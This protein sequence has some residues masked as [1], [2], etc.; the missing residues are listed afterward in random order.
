[1]AV[2]WRRFQFFS[3]HVLVDNDESV[4]EE[5]LFSPASISTAPESAAELVRLQ[6][7]DEDG[8]VNQQLPEQSLCEQL[9]YLRDTCAAAGRNLLALGDQNG[10]IH[11]FDRQLHIHVFDAF[12]AK[13]GA[14]CLLQ[15]R[16]LLIAAG[17]SPDSHP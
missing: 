3:E 1:M 12:E 6:A 14:L 9:Q 10:R 15:E 11:V 4:I 7:L 13:V 5:P 2:H 17:K 8:L 16:P